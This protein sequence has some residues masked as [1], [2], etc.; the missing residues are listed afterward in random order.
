MNSQVQRHRMKCVWLNAVAVSFPLAL[1][2]ITFCTTSLLGRWPSSAAASREVLDNYNLTCDVPITGTIRDPIQRDFLIFSVADGEVV[3]ISLINSTPAGRNFQVVGRLLSG[4]GQPVAG[5]C[6]S[7]NLGGNNRIFNCGPLPAAGNP[8]RVEVVDGSLDDTGTYRAQLQRLM[9]TAACENTLFTC[10]ITH[11]GTIDSPVDTDLYRF[12]VAEG[13]VVTISLINGTSAGPNFQ[14]VGRLLKGDGT[15]AAGPCGGYNL[16]GNN[17]I[18]NCGPLPASGNPYRVEVV[19]GSLDDTGTYRA[20]LQRLTAA[21][22]CDTTA[23]TCDA[24]FTGMIDSPVDTDLLGFSVRESEVVSISLVNNTPAGPNF[25]VVGRLLSGN[26]QPVAGPCGSYNLGGNNRIFNCGPLPAAGNPYR[27]EVVD[28]SLDDSGTYR[29]VVSFL[30]TGCPACVSNNLLP[31]ELFFSNFLYI[32]APNGIGD[33]LLVGNAVDPRR[34]LSLIPPPNAPNQTYCEPVEL[35]PGRFATAYVPTPQERNGDFSAFAG[36]LLDPLTNTPFPG[37]IIPANRIGQGGVF[38]WRIAR[39]LGTLATVSAAS[40]SGTMLAPDSIAA[41]FGSGLATATQAATLL[42]L[43]TTLAGTTAKIRDSANTTRDVPLFFAAPTQINCHLLP[44]MAAG[45]A[46][47]SITSGNGTVS[48]G[49]VQI[50][51]VAPALFAANAN[52]QGVAAAVIL[53]VSSNGLQ[54][55][56]P[57]ARF[58]ATLNRYVPL[59]IDLGPES[60]QVFLLLFGT[61]FRS[62]SNLMAVTVSIGGQEAPVS[63]AG[64]APGLVGLD[65]ANA[66]LPRSLIGRGEVDVALTVDGKPANVVRVSFK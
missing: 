62:R 43:P 17:R 64:L 4:N 30:T 51:A 34:L 44:T 45:K 2:V 23:L 24:I 59:P 47:L 56:E 20:Q 33:R 61:G 58:D 31:N 9:A 36:L 12:D 39:S 10:D 60:D 52:G 21:T 29:A 3:T 37:G 32:S 22:A 27:A 5:S 35:S 41:V 63:Y 40:Y 7:Y 49:V 26:G 19:D 55:F 8:Y 53:R 16:G 11:T 25:Q 14:V 65:Q 6:G 66:R 50:A 13:E 15:P 57:V 42:P 38:A 28:G 18:F 1:A 54:V 46:V 48:M